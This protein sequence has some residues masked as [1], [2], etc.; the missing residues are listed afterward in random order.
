MAK[1]MLFRAMLSVKIKP[2]NSAFINTQRSYLHTKE[3]IPT[4]EIEI[5]LQFGHI[6]AKVW[7][8]DQDRPILALHGWQDNAGTWDTL[9]PLL[10][11]NRSIMAIDF[12]GHGLSSWIP[13]GLH[14]YAWELPRLILYL[15]NYF[16]WDKVSLLCHSMGSIA[17]LRYASVFQDDVDFYVAVDSLIYDD[18]DLHQIVEKFPVILNKIEVAQTRLHEEPPSYTLEEI[19]MKWHLG[20]AKSV[21]LESTKYL[22]RRG[23]KPA[24]RDPNKYYFCRDARLK[25]SLFQPENK[26]FVEALVKRLKC[27]TLYVKAIDSP[28]ASDEFSVEMREVIERN[29]EN[30]EIHF[31]PGTHHVHLNNPERVAPLIFKFL[32][33][34]NFKI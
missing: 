27:P 13:P 30:Y 34:Y 28:F 7:G 4:K 19:A 32:Q 22:M 1:R 23:I 18:F 16:K 31:L 33:K 6:A 3:K 15:K 14:Y 26:K 24:S 20:T 8:N 11:E 25:H 2:E 17:G 9:A 21:S 29:N 10:C 5:P 12:P